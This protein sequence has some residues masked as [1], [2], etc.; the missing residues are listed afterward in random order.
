M[1]GEWCYFKGVFSPDEC[2]FILR[3]GL[4]I[5]SE[6]AKMGVGKEIINEEYR[7]SDIRFITK[8]NSDFEFLFDKMWKLAIQ[9][10]NDWFDFHITK[11]DYIQLAEYSAENNGV[12]KTHQDVFWINN[13]SAYHRKLTCVVQLTDSNDY[14]GGNFELHNVMQTPNVEEI[15]T[16]GTA[17]FIP[18]FVY[19][20]A[21]EVTEGKRHSLAVWFDGP[22]WR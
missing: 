13:D 8:Q 19:H 15:R 10:N 7:K 17:I 1:R 21:T 9:A 5:P 4:K 20:A 14:Q 12:Y 2:D 18:S 22:K 6:K 11:L 3:E 16:R